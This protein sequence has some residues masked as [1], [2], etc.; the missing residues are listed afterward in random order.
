MMGGG[1]PECGVD[2]HEVMLTHGFYLDIY[3]VT[4]QQYLDAIQWAY[5]HGYVYANHTIATDLLDDAS[6]VLMYLDRPQ[7]ELAFYGGIFS[8][9]DA[10]HGINPDHPVKI[11][12]WYGAARYCDWKSMQ[13]GFPRAYEHSGE[14]DCNHGEPYQAAGYRL[15]TDAEW[16]YASQWND[17]RVYPWGDD[18]PDCDILNFD[19]CDV[20][21]VPA[22]TYDPAPQVLGLWNMGGN[23][24]EW[25]NDWFVCDL[26]V[27]PAVNPVG[28]ESGTYRVQ[29]GGTFTSYERIVRCAYRA[30][31]SPG[32]GTTTLGFR[33]ARTVHP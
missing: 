7:C 19:N 14:W 25:C 16:E 21:T 8:L 20:W 23:V 3:E 30:G 1:V 28:P 17:D 6:E 29:R 11:V 31:N 9:R 27:A 2:E 18:P 26:G 32:S 12:T 24:A 33:I 13:E 4:N 15:P 5:D 10:G 22:G